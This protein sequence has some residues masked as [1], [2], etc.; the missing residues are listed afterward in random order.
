MRVSVKCSSAVHILLMIAAL[1]PRCKVTSEFLASSV[2]SNPVEIRKLLSALKKAGLIHVSRGP[3]GAALAREP[4]DISL[5]D[6]YAA[7]DSSSLDELIGVHS[8]PE[9]QCPFGKNIA[10]LLAEPYAEIGGA[11]R[12]KMAGIRLADLLDRLHAMEPDMDQGTGGA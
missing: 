1:S 11:I 2:G 6:I 9:P 10:A 3:G 5:L 8:H 7:V 12:E 4:R